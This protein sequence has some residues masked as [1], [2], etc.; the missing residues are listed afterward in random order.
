[1]IGGVGLPELIIILVIFIICVFP[2]FLLVKILNKAGFSGWFSLIG[3]IP[4]VNL[5]FLWI[6]AFISWPSENKETNAS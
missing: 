4:F 3:L 2:I 6:F 5:A 1:M